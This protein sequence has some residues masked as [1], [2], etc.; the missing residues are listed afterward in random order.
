MCRIAAMV[1][2][3]A[4]GKYSGKFCFVWLLLSRQPAKILKDFPIKDRYPMQAVWCPLSISA[5][6][7]VFVVVQRIA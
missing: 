5:H 4:A 1:S 7:A 3:G 2:I 6:V